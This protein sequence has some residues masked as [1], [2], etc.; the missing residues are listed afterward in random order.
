M[1]KATF[2]NFE[3]YFCSKNSNIGTNASKFCMKLH[4]STLSGKNTLILWFSPILAEKYDLKKINE[5][6]IP[7]GRNELQLWKLASG[8][9]KIL[10]RNYRKQNFDYWN[11][12]DFIAYF[13]KILGKKNLHIKSEKNKNSAFYKFFVTYIFFILLPWL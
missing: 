5:N 10:Q 11:F 2:G 7:A 8:Y 4:F 1:I 13:R 9:R 12:L 3:T 6:C